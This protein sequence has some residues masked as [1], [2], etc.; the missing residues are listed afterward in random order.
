MMQIWAEIQFTTIFPQS[1]SGSLQLSS[2]LATWNLNSYRKTSSWKKIFFF[3]LFR[4]TWGKKNFQNRT[5]DFQIKHV[6][7]SLLLLWRKGYLLI[8]SH[9]IS[10]MNLSPINHRYWHQNLSVSIPFLS[11]N[12]CDWSNRQ[13]HDHYWLR[14]MAGI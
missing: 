5:M 6:T 14:V 2:T 4:Q 1:V 13:I 3:Y 9:K 12:A 7:N 11:P 10:K 8:Y